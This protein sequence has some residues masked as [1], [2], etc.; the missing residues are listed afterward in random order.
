M[1]AIRWSVFAAIAMLFLIQPSIAIYCDE[2]DCYDL[3]GYA[4]FYLLEPIFGS[5]SGHFPAGSGRRICRIKGALASSPRALEHWMFTCTN[6]VPGECEMLAQ[7]GLKQGFNGIE[8][9]S[10]WGLNSIPHWK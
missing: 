7:S 5:T 2:D 6:R 3:L 4:P 1:P 10:M 8:L 9:H